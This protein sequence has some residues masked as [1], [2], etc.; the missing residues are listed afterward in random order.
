MDNMRKI[1]ETLS[2]DG[3]KAIERAHEVADTALEKGRQT[4]KE[5]RGQGQEALDHAQESAQEVWDDAQKLVQKH[6]GEAVGLAL[7]IG[8]V[9]GGALVAMRKID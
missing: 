5:L 9:I 1:T 2:K 8:A 3:E 4:W 6:P 7:L